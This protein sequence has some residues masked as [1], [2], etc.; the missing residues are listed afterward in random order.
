MKTVHI[1]ERIL[2]Q[3]DDVTLE[4]KCVIERLTKTDLSRALHKSSL[5]GPNCNKTGRVY[6]NLSTLDLVP[7]L[8]ATSNFLLTAQS[9]HP[10]PSRSAVDHLHKFQNQRRAILMCR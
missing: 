2:L 9:I 5:P 10:M 4:A 1:F 7:A 6:L 8:L 3:F